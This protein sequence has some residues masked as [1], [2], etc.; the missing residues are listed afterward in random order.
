M[1]TDVYLLTKLQ[2]WFFTSPLERTR[3]DWAGMAQWYSAGLRSGWSGVR[4]PAGVGNFSLPTAS[5]PALGPTHPPIQWVLGAL[6]PG[7]KRPGRESDHSPPTSAEV[8]E[9]VELYLYFHNTPAWC[10]AQLKAQGKLYLYKS[11]WR[12]FQFV[13]R[14]L[15]KSVKW[16]YNFFANLY[17]IS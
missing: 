8:K 4:I 6:S 15:T 2:L 13:M 9:W 11:S 3:E 1:Y 16:T 5:R 12:W 10:D 14:S 17:L 7:V